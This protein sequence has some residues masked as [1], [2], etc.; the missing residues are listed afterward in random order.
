[1]AVVCNASAVVAV[2]R[3]HLA[4]V[5]A[6]YQTYPHVDMFETGRRAGSG[7]SGGSTGAG[8]DGFR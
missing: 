5:V 2:K 6:G 7:G 1:M 4:Q 3:V 8:D